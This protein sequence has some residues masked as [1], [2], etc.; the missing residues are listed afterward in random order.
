[1]GDVIALMSDNDAR[2]FEVYWAA[3]RSGLYMTS[4]NYRLRPDEV[5]YILEN[6]GARALLVGR[7]GADVAANLGPIATLEHRIAFDVDVPGFRSLEEV[8]ASA[9][10]VPPSHEPRGADMLYSSGTTGR[11]KGVRPPLPDRDVSAPGDT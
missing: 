7:G 6:S 1:R 2:V 10:P 9:S 4:I 11:P 3:Q 8:V 5:E